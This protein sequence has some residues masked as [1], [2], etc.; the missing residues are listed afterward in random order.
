MIG[1]LTKAKLFSD[2]NILQTKSK[3]EIKKIALSFTLNVTSLFA[4]RE[5]L[6]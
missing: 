5:Q 3:R 6:L 4:P 2:N 1:I